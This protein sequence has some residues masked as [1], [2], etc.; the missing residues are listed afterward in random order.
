MFEKFLDEK[1]IKKLKKEHKS[2]NNSNGNMNEEILKSPPK[3]IIPPISNIRKIMTA[4][5][6]GKKKLYFF[7]KTRIFIIRSSL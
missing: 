7:I 6:E 3:A 5:K 1:E 4:L 2:L